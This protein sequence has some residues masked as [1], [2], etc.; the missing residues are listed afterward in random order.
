MKRTGEVDGGDEGEKRQF[1]AATM[2]KSAYEQNMTQLRPAEFKIADLEELKY[3]QQKKRTEYENALRRNRFN[4][5]QWLRYAQFEIEQKD[6]QRARSVFERAIEVDYKNVTVWI[7]YIQ[8]EIKGKNI[9]HARNLLERATKL[10]PMVDKLWYTYITVEE[11]IGNVIAVNTIFEKWL[12]WKPGKNVWLSY[13][14]FKERYA[15]YQDGRLIFEKLV[16]VFNDDDL[17][18]KWTEYEKKYGDMVNVENVFKLGVNALYKRNKL[19][20]EFIIH[21]IRYEYAN[22]RHD[23]VKQ[24]YEF[25]FSSLSTEEERKLRKFQA[26]FKEQFGVDSEDIE[27]Y[28]LEKRR[29]GYEEKLAK[30]PRDYETWWTYLNLL[31]DSNLVVKKDDISEAFQKSVANIPS[32]LKQSE[33]IQF[34]YLNLRYCLYL[35]WEVK[36]VYKARD[37]YEELV[38]IIPHKDVSVVQFWIKYAEFELRNFDLAAMRKVLG[39]AIGLTRFEEIVEHYIEIEKRLK[40]FDRARR[41]YDKLVELNP[42]NWRYWAEYFNFEMGLGNEARA[43]SIVEVS[44]FERFVNVPGKRKIIGKVLGAIVE[45]FNFRLGRKLVEYKVEISDRNVDAVI[46]R[47]LFELRVPSEA[48]IAKYEEEGEAE[49]EGDVEVEFEVDE[50]VKSR[51]RAEYERWI[52]DLKNV[53]EKRIML[54]ESLKKFEE[55]YG[56]EESVEK[57]VKRL[58]KIVKKVRESDGMKEEFIEYVFPEDEEKIREQV[59]EFKSD[60]LTNV[61]EDDEE[62]VDDEEEEEEG[63]AEDEDVERLQEVKTFKSRFASDS[64]DDGN[65]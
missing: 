15:E 1:T 26:D 3:Y 49:G 14:E 38:K 53:V 30:N 40:Y 32:T 34:W 31:V 13:I 64:E 42:G 41:L 27:V 12:Q 54:L 65:E 44:V 29:V 36:D 60:F 50:S 43:Y 37:K 28:I 23:K 4:F 48:Q 33:W 52:S 20:A 11:S 59:D 39:Q 25:G 55:E 9:N 10:L 21:W 19:S 16:T 45:N 58:P 22:K 17:W 35:E 62:D 46:E 51:V 57:V 56:D 6:I 8:C 5:G 47:C 61:D 24:L 7:R 18:I 2:L 63:D